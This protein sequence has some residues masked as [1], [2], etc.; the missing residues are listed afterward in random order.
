MIKPGTICIWQNVVGPASVLNGTECTALTSL[1]F[2][3]CFSIE[4]LFTGIKLVYETDS[5]FN[6][7]YMPT[8]LIFAAP[9]E[10]REKNAPKHDEE[11][12]GLYVTLNIEGII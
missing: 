12:D 10:L 9:H 4:G 2:R 8:G 11:I 5:N 3:Q 7:L 1:M 6:Y